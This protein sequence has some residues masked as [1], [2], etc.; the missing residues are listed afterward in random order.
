MSRIASYAMFFSLVL[1]V[2][3]GLHFYFWVRFV[4][5][6]GL[7]GNARLAATIV[8]VFL[9]VSMPASMALSHVLPLGTSRVALAMP[10]FWMGMALL[11]FFLL[12]GVD[13]LRC[14]AWIGARLAGRPGLWPDP[15]TKLLASRIVAM[16]TL[17]AAVGMC[18]YGTWNALKP[19]AVRRVTVELAKLPAE[20]RG[21][22]IAILSDLHLG[23]N[24]GREWTADV[25]RRTNALKPDLVAVLGD[26]PDGS[27]E[28]LGDAA[29][30]LAG[31]RAEQGVFFVTGNHE[32]YS[33]LEEWLS[34]VRKLGMRVL[35]NERVAIGKGLFDLVGLPDPHIERSEGAP[36][37]DLDKALAGRDLSRE[38]ILLAH[39]PR[40][41]DDAVR[42][43]VGLQLSG[44]THG[45]QFWPWKYLVRLQQPFISGLHREGASQIYV[46]EGTGLWGPLMRIGTSSEI[47][48][49]TLVPTS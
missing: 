36:R 49:V 3:L 17:S 33:G 12:L 8:L 43:G 47:T 48:L 46:T 19:P 22:T 25:V 7:S 1:T 20:A 6:T 38:M 2:M 24:R 40:A 34:F 37:P 45:G 23:P 26:I 41:F 21:F 29:L 44:H 31:L 10:Y 28:L 16:G 15:A 5:D 42:L 4:R 13:A 9:A 27:V 11:L 39:Q 18:A 35:V 14:L 32:Y 30:P